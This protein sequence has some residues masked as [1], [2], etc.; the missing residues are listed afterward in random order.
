MKHA[1]KVIKPFEYATAATTAEP[2][3]LEEKFRQIRRRQERQRQAAEALAQSVRAERE[4]VVRKLA[5]VA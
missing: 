3:Y 1:G 5:K 4:R 2:G